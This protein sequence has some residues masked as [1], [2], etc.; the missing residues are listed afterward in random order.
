MDEGILSRWVLSTLTPL[1]TLVDRITP[2]LT[3]TARNHLQAVLAM[4]GASRPTGG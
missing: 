4:S 2:R 1:D 3:P